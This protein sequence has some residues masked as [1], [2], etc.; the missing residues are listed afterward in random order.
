VILLLLLLTAV[1]GAV[2]ADHYQP[3]VNDGGSYW[4]GRLVADS[5]SFRGAGPRATAV[6]NAF[7]TEYR[8]G[9]FPH[10][11]RL[12]FMVDIFNS[13]RFPV[14]VVGVRRLLDPPESSGTRL[15]AATDLLDPEGSMRPVREVT[16][17]AHGYQT[18]G[19][20]ADVRDCGQ[21]LEP[22]AKTI[23]EGVSLRYRFAGFT[24]EANIPLSDVAFSLVGPPHCS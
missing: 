6:E 3:L 19:F 16:I 1:S 10:G 5:S 13:G 11:G 20:A 8:I 21:P 9:P 14:T 12:G 7:G 2:W 4:G 24:H 23:L 17:P 15:F 22:D 18:F